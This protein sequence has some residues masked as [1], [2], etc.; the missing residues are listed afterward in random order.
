MDENLILEIRSFVKAIVHHI[1]GRIRLRLSPELF[2][3]A[4]KIDLSAFQNLDGIKEIQVNPL[5]LSAVI[6]YDPDKL[7]PRLWEAFIKDEGSAAQ[8]INQLLSGKK[9]TEVEEDG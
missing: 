3:K 1:P 7:P 8:V 9:K 5:A 6:T 4:G 2:V